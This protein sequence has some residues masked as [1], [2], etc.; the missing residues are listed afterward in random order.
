MKTPRVV[1][2]APVAADTK[3]I[4]K[5]DSTGAID[6]ILLGIVAL[7]FTLLVFYVAVAGAYDSIFGL[8]AAMLGVAAGVFWFGTFFE[9]KGG[10]I[11]KS[12]ALGIAAFLFSAFTL[13]LANIFATN[14]GLIIFL[15]IV[16]GV[17]WPVTSAYWDKI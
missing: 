17:L 5:L 7:F 3:L 10:R 12:I 16:A 9:A 6:C 2:S 13:V 4:K 14:G 15:G 8:I 1:E 11:A